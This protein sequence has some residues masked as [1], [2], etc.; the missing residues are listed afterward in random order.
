M[1]EVPVSVSGSVRAQSAP[2]VGGAVP[3]GAVPAAPS[4]LANPANPQSPA[5]A[6]SASAAASTAA[7]ATAAAPA[8]ATAP[9][10]IPARANN[11]TV[12][13]WTGSLEQGRMQICGLIARSRRHHQEGNV[14]EA[15]LHNRREDVRAFLW[16]LEFQ[17]SGPISQLRARQNMIDKALQLLFKDT[18]REYVPADISR[19]AATVFALFD[20][21]NWGAGGN[22]TNSAANAANAAA[23]AAAAATIAPTSTA[24]TASTNAG[25]SSA[26]PANAVSANAAPANA[27]PANAVPANAAPANAAPADAAP[28]NGANTA[29]NAVSAPVPAPG[30]N[31]DA[32]G[33]RLPPANHPIWGTNG[34]MHGMYMVRGPGNR[35]TYRYDPRYIHQKRDARVIGAN[36]LVPGAWWPLQALAVF[37][38]AHGQTIRGIS[39]SPTQGAYSIVISGRARATYAHLDA[40]NGH[41]VQ[42]ASDSP[43]AA[44]SSDTRALQTSLR[45]G[46]PVRVLRGAGARAHALAPPVGIRYDGLYRVVASRRVPDHR[47]EEY[48]V[49]RLVREPGQLPLAQICA[50]SPTPAQIRAERRLRRGY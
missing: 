30:S 39:G 25:P 7:A 29:N 10:A 19:T 44:P 28:A 50:A 23:A 43:A 13:A 27:V 21:A 9:A 37:H 17:Y 24:N 45:T 32:N 40:D 47:G 11:T 31:T 15:E 48:L 41:T 26:A 36:G 35:P 34:I 3:G 46:A 14:P 18:H 8:A 38:G 5:P 33:N 1:A 12:R 16:Y 22:N 20:R 49:F 6:N 42:Y 4:G 2:G